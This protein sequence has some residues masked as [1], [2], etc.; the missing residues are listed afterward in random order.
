[1]EDATSFGN[2]WYKLVKQSWMTEKGQVA[3]AAILFGANRHTLGAFALMGKYWDDFREYMSKVDEEPGD[4]KGEL[5]V[6]LGQCVITPCLCH[7]ITFC[8]E[9]NL[10]AVRV[11]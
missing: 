6:G 2:D 1:M 8:R 3:I 10:R 11:M 5:D 7:F 9:R 4:I